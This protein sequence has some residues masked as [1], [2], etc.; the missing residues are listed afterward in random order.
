VRTREELQ[1]ALP[2]LPIL[3]VIPRSRA[4]RGNG[5]SRINVVEGESPS[6]EAYRQLRTNLSFARPGLPQQVIVLTSP[7]PGDGKSMTSTNLAATLAQQGGRCLLIDADMRRGALN[8]AFEVRRDPGLSQ[9]LASQ[10]PF[11]DAVHTVQLTELRASFDFLTGGVHPPNPAELLGSSRFKELIASC[12]E[13]YDTVIIDA[14][15]L[16][17]VTDASVMGAAADGVLVVVRAGI[18]RGDALDFAMDQLESVRA[19]LLGVI[20]NDV[21]PRSEGYYGKYAGYYGRGQGA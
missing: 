17:L 7:T 13:S 14:P 10:V 5:G 2:G 1:L 21:N 3:S 8:E 16:N 20:L 6:A 12:R 9:V 4:A 19:P 15:P 18:T 11:R